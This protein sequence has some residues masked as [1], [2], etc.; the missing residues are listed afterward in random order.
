[1]NLVVIGA[2]GFIGRNVVAYG[3]SV[4][5]DVQPLRAPRISPVSDEPP[6]GRE[7][8]RRGRRAN[9]EAF[10]A[11]CRSLEPFDVVVNASGLAN[12][13][14]TD[15]PLLRAA[16]VTL[17]AVV[18][19]AA[20][21]AGARRL[22]HVSSAAVQGRLD[23]L[24]ESPR[25]FPLSPYARSKADGEQVLL[26]DVGAPLSRPPEVLVYRPTSVVG[27]GRPVARQLVEVARTLPFVPVA[28]AGRQPVPVALV[29]N[30]AA[31]IVFAATM[32]AC[33]PIVVQPSEAMTARRLWEIFG[34]RR[35]VSV[36][37]RLAQASLR[38][39]ARVAGS[40][41]Q[42]TARLRWAE[43]ALV[44]QG[45]RAEALP[46]AGFQPPFGEERWAA[47]VAEERTAAAGAGVGAPSTS[48]GA[49]K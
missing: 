25:W 33:P 42:L 38:T 43:L 3:R 48:A 11:L 4:G 9:A 27:G 8:A 46:S 39:A 6:D 5:I 44:G 13:A 19:E 30:V 41:P 26:S 28:G 17:P 40:R 21:A 7:A 34:A 31:G 24:D 1:V 16:N 32:P 49:R 47:L 2:S 22:V 36:P 23:P 12:P 45:V 35:M 29:E 20:S 15:W 37:E 18:A 10:R 14:A